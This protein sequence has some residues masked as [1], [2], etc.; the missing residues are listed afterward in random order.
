MEWQDISTAPKDGRDVLVYDQVYGVVSA[1]F[2]KYY[3]YPHPSSRDSDS[4]EPTHWMPLP[5][6]PTK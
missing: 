1:Y 6:P 2:D 3:W 4:L 5:K